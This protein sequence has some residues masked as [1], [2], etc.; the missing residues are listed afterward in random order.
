M[1]S[2]QD[3]SA[4][5]VNDPASDDFQRGSYFGFA[6]SQTALTFGEGVFASGKIITTPI[7]KRSD[8]DAAIQHPGQIPDSVR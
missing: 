6:E 4:N 2:A 8:H 3:S 5:G 7:P 1:T